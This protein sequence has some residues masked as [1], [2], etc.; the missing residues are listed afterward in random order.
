MRK[1]NGIMAFSAI[2]LFLVHGILSS[3]LMMDITSVFIKELPYIVAGIVGVHALISIGY[4][5]RTLCIA[6][7]THAPYFKENRLYWSRRISGLVILC[8]ISFHML[9]FTDNN[10]GV[11]RLIPFDL[12][13]LIM[14][15]L[16]LCSV[17]V[18]L[19]ANVK[20]IL[21]SFG[22]R[23]LRQKWGTVLFFVSAGLLVMTIGFIV[24][25]VRW[26]LNLA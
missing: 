2:V 16:F 20:P 1:L 10:G 24:Y 17:A 14:Q 15:L 8:L 6:H 7:R 3:L 11:F 13:R 12:F 19:I 23:K 22:T 25:Y 5:I 9:A 18:H 4:T 21:I 26:Q